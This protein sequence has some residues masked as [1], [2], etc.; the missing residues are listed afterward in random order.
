MSLRAKSLV[1]SGITAVAL[2][3]AA[4]PAVAERPIVEHFHDSDSIVEEGFCG[5]LTVR[6]DRDI[7]GT[8]LA[9]GRGRHRQVVPL[10]T[11]HGTVSF[12]NLANDRSL[13]LS[14]AGVSNVI[15]V[16][17][18]GDGTLTALVMETGGER[19]HGPD[20][21]LLLLNP[22]QIR[23]ELLVDHGGTPTDLA[24]DQVLE[25]LGLVKGSTGRNDTV[26]RDF[27]DDIHEFIG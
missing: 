7:R 13:T 14:F 1:A 10:E 21:K 6:I 15:A 19:W 27:C 17:D 25:F 24:D 3:S 9:N 11:S 26:G 18:N 2:A 16:T 20:G 8:F 12:T 4:G 5:D 22:G 23:F